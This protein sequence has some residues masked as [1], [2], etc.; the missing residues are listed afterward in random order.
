MPLPDAG[1]EK[2]KNYIPMSPVETAKLQ[3]IATKLLDRLVKELAFYGAK[4]TH[5]RLLAMA[6]NPF[7]A[8]HGMEELDLLMAVIVDDPTYKELIATVL[9]DHK[10]TAM[11]ILAQEIEGDCSH[12]IPDGNGN[13][14]EGGNV[15]R[16]GDDAEAEELDRVEALRRKRAKKRIEGLE[17]GNNQDLDPVERQVHEFFNQQFDPRSGMP[18]E[19]HSLV[20]A[21]KD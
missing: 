15:V 4:P 6:C 18:S 14:G 13:G 16:D 3:P 7:M 11:D 8:T 19:T 5:D 12:I 10:K 21:T 1:S 17:I 9:V 2:K 20:G